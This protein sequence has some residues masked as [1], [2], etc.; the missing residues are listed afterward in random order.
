MA[1]L[2]WNDP[3]ERKQTIP[4]VSTPVTL[5][6]SRRKRT[7]E[8]EESSNVLGRIATELTRPPETPFEKDL[9]AGEEAVRGA[10]RSAA[11]GVSNLVGDI[12]QRVAAGA[13]GLASGVSNY[14]TGQ[15]GGL[16]SPDAKPPIVP[17]PITPLPAAAQPFAPPAA[18]SGVVR[19]TEKRL[20]LSQFGAGGL[21]SPVKSPSSLKE[22]D[23]YTVEGNKMVPKPV[24]PE[25]GVSQPFAP[26]AR[27]YNAEIDDLVNKLMSDPK[28]LITQDMGGGYIKTGGLKK[29]VLSAIATLKGHQ[30]GLQGQREVAASG[31]E[32]QKIQTAG[33]KATAEA[34]KL[35]TR[36]IADESREE[37][38]RTAMES[39]RVREA[40]LAQRTAAGEETTALRSDIA[41]ERSF[42]TALTK[43]GEDSIAGFNA[44]KGLFEMGFQGMH[45][46]RPEVQQAY[47]PFKAKL[48]RAF[49]KTPTAKEKK[50]S[51]DDWYSK[52][53]WTP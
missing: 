34:S 51:R 8:P 13:R 22:S 18:P 28:S 40:E 6:P 23:Y 26:P 20:D 7:V 5:P 33:T 1:G 12:P 30:L 39:I 15:G 47:L 36:Q 19:P 53:G 52:M 50:I 38:K 14:F 4:A 27:D 46:D 10:V 16:L 32:G 29:N 41:K 25:L 48:E 37:R 24:A 44:G 21:Q 45:A 42:Q 17:S 9:A 3:E 49:G 35:A 2:Q 43:Y 31:L 11:T